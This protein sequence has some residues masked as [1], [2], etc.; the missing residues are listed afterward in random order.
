MRRAS[1]FPG[2]APWPH[3]TLMHL[4]PMFGE[5]FD[6]RN[7]LA[8][9]CSCLAK[10]ISAGSD[11][12]TRRRKPGSALFRLAGMIGPDQKINC[13]HHEQREQRPDASPL[14]ITSPMLKRET[15]PAPLATISGTTP[16]T[17]AAVVIRIGRNRI[18]GRLLD[19]LAL[20][21]AAALQIVCE[22]DNQNRRA[23]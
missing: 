6:G 12:I 19:S 15:A 16:S 22:L 17:M 1:V 7:Q 21:C 20:G 10:P 2:H 18:A 23:C 4:S 14:A 9:V 13:R 11:H 5:Q 8:E 3:S